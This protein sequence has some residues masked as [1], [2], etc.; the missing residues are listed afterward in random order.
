MVSLSCQEFSRGHSSMFDSIERKQLSFSLWASRAVPTRRSILDPTGLYLPTTVC[1]MKK[2]VHFHSP[3]KTFCYHTFEYARIF[4]SVWFLGQM[5]RRVRR[6]PLPFTVLVVGMFLGVTAVWNAW[7]SS[8]KYC[9]ES[10]LRWRLSVGCYETVLRD[11]RDL[12]RREV[13]N[14]LWG[15]QA[16]P[17]SEHFNCD[18]A[19][20]KVSKKSNKASETM[21]DLLK[22]TLRKVCRCALSGSH[23]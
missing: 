7:W 16:E 8:S 20:K 3:S 6:M 12:Y 4:M 15:N 19:F 5:T 23:R 2:E 13:G 17:G 11:I 1:G 18:H 21:Q 14:R 10:C 22:K 9:K